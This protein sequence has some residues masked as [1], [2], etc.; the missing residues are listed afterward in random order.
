MENK[1]ISLPQN[2]QFNFYRLFGGQLLSGITS[3][4]VQYALIWFMTMTYKSPSVLAFATMLSTI[5][6]IVLAPFVG[7]LVDR[8]NKKVLLIG[9]DMIVA[10]AALL[11]IFS[12]RESTLPLYIVY[13]AI[14]IRS[15]AQTLQ[16]PMIQSIV[17][18]LVPDNFL[19]K[20]N[21]QIG[22]FN[23]I[24]TVLAP[25]L[26]FL[27]YSNLP[28]ASVMW[29]DI[30]GAVIGSIT[31]L[32]SVI[33]S[34][35]QLSQVKITVYR[36]VAAGWKVMIGQ[37]GVLQLII[38]VSLIMVAFVPISSMYPLFTT[39]YF[40]MSLFHA[41][42]VETIFSI[43]MVVGGLT[44]G[45]FSKVKQFIHPV[46]IAIMF[47]GAMFMFSGVLPG[48]ELGFWLFFTFNIVVG[49]AIPIMNSFLMTIIQKSYPPEYLGRVMG[50]TMP[51]QAAS[52][53]IG[54]AFIGPLA[55]QYGISTMFLWGGIAEI[56]LA[57]FAYCLPAI[58]NISTKIAD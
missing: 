52:G 43:G 48:N 32:L 37:R 29:I 23:A 22:S 24:S 21:G 42:L 12:N 31:V 5:P 17:P 45:L 16:Q 8:L 38:I 9:G 55:E 2:W 30:V 51:L 20:A 26:G 46:I 4:T 18:T 25:T 58:R 6:G 34:F 57:I 35:N 56:A 19:V 28:L 7:P 10:V 11:I 40:K 1:K 15:V 41:N 50:V 13:T 53:P 14:F 27:T 39:E 54:L 49:L 44:L 36:D 3:W 47:M 33:P